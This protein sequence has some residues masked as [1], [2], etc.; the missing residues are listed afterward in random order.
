LAKLDQVELDHLVGDG[1]NVEDVYP[2]TATQAGMVF[3]RLSQADQG[4]YFQQLTFVLGGVP[5]AHLFTEAWQRVVDRTAVLRCHVVWEGADEWLQVVKRNVAVPVE[6]HDWTR[7]SET[8]RREELDQLLERDR[9]A[10]LDLGTAPLMRLTLV[11]LS[12]TELRVVWTFDHVLLD[13]WSVFHVLSDVFAA[14]AQLRQHAEGPSGAGRT[15]LALPVRPPFREFLRWLSAQDRHDGIGYWKGLLGTLSEATPLPYDR[16]PVDAHRSRSRE[17]ARFELSIEESAR[18]RE[19]AQRNGLTVNTLVQGAWAMLLSRYSGQPEVVFGTTV[20]GRPPE[21]PGVESMIGIFISTLPT[22]VAV[23][24]HC[25]LVSWLRELQVSQSESR[26]FDFVPLTQLQGLSGLPGGVNLFDSLVVFENYPINDEI[27]AA[28]GLDLSE[29]EALET[30]NYALGVV[31]TTGRHLSFQLSYDHDLFNSDTVER[32]AGHLKTLLDRTADDPYRPL[33]ELSMLT[34]V[35]RDQVVLGWNDT[36]AVLPVEPVGTLFAE[37]VE[38]CG[39]AP[40]LYFDDVVLSYG[41]LDARANRL[42]RYLIGRGIG[43]EQF[44]AVAL[45]RS[46]EAIVALLAVL[47]AGAAYLP[48][49]PEYPAERI[50]FMLDDARPSLVVTTTEVTANLPGV[51]ARLVLDDVETAAEVERC[52]AEAVAVVVEPMSPAYLIYTS[53]STGRPK[54]VVVS[55]A[56]VASLLATQMQRLGVGPGSRVLQFASLS[57]DAAFWELCMGLLSGAA[58]VVARADRLVPGESLVELAAEYELT[59]VTLPPVVLA[60]TDPGDGVLS[61][62]TLVVAGEACSADLVAR[63]SPGR[64]LIN[65]YGPTESTVCATMTAPLTSAMVGGGGP[66]IGRPVVNSQIYVL[67][68]GLRPVPVGVAG[69]LYIA[70]AGLARGYYNRPGLTA[71]RFVA[72]PFGQPGAR[73]YQTGDLVRWRADGQ[74]DF[75]GRVDDQVK[76]RGF[77]IEPGEVEAV[78]SSHPAVEAVAV[79]AR[80][81]KPGVKRLVAYLIPAAGQSVESGQLRGFLGAV[82]PDYMVPSAFVGLSEFPLTANG[83]LDRRGLPAPDESVGVGTGFV[84][85]RTEVERVLVGIWAE[86]LG[87]AR[88]GV[89]DNFFE[90][91]GDSILSIQVVSRARRAGLGLMPRDVFRHQTV[92][93]LA[94]GVVVVAPSALDVAVQGPVVGAV[95]LTPVQCWL[96]AGGVPVVERF[97]Q[98]VMV[99]LFAGVDES[100]LG[101]ALGALVEHHD[102][103]RMRF[104][105]RGGVWSQE[106]TG[107]VSGRVWGPRRV[108]VGG[109]GVDERA[110]VIAATVEQVYA[111][112]DLGRPPLLRA[113]L[114]DRGVGLGPVLFLAVHHLVVDGVSWRILLEDLDSAYRLAAQGRVLEGWGGHERL[115]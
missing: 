100:A 37:Q 108:D 79:V 70:G 49:D 7:L 67:D 19:F 85:A 65:A 57:F 42:A 72:N 62:A 2:L 64:R 106:N 46:V 101:A 115:G 75:L 82:L 29:L 109:L 43:P 53:G 21:L 103:L 47:K 90:L 96:F 94:A 69:E 40:A 5:D 24:G 110:V 68:A 88:V 95:A 84:A 81:D 11:R 10:G 8:R 9:A 76:I 38:R 74:L 26:R 105:C 58:L 60:A 91:G 97:S 15:E 34:E 83:K 54:G 23:D 112:F 89:E 87:R 107:P 99:E 4:V 59:H 56:G 33:A 45:P 73:M 77:R 98:S 92:A 114:F 13:G 48:V 16:Q 111:D 25:D 51:G 86:V 35:E 80:E 28:N 50:A 18:L 32:M 20:S 27:A 31:V 3:H 104:E 1:R 102:A 61:G 39:T 14:H 22:R 66:P 71:Q 17:T 36:Q 113:V 52:G 78:L 30:T 41:E 63:W 12:G 6:Y 55:H 93:S 44:V